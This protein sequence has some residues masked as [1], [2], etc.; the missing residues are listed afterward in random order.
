VRTRLFLVQTF[1]SP[2]IELQVRDYRP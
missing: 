1:R 2:L